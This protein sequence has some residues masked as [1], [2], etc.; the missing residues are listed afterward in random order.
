[1]E[2]DIAFG[3]IYFQAFHRIVQDGAE[4]DLFISGRYVDRYERRAG[5]WKIAHRS[6]LVDWA[7]T[8][9]AADDWLKATPEVLVGHRGDADLSNQRNRLRTL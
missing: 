1:M 6:E 4:Q 3:E 9:P 5:V 8:E 7:R 2:G